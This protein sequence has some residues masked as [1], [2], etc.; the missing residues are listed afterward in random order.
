MSGMVSFRSVIETPYAFRGRLSTFGD[1]AGNWSPNAT[2]FGLKGRI[3]TRNTRKSNDKSVRVVVCV[4]FGRAEPFTWVGTLVSAVS[5]V[6]CVLFESMIVR[7]HLCVRVVLVGVAPDQGGSS[8]LY[9]VDSWPSRLRL[10]VRGSS[11][12]KSGFRSYHVSA[13]HYTR[14]YSRPYSGETVVLLACVVQI[15]LKSQSQRVSMLSWGRTRKHSVLGRT[16]DSLE[17]DQL[18]KL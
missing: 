17:G 15:E 3:H 4:T 8:T 7:R 16:L 12:A 14:R 2:S 9:D 13:Y 5:W 6:V 18:Y 11:Y 1:P 10:I